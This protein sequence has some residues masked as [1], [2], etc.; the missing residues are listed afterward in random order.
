MFSILYVDDEPD[1][2]DL[3]KIFLEQSPDFHVAINT[4]AIGALALPE[5]GSFD[6]IISDFQMPEMDGIAFLKSIRATRGNVP[7]IL[8]TGRGREEIVI[9]AINNGVDFYLQKGG[10]VKAQFAELSHKIRQAV[11]RRRAEQSLVESEKRLTDII[12]FLPDP[13]FAI[14]R[15]GEII[16]WNHAIEEMTGQ[17]ASSMLGKGDHE[18]AIPFYGERR[19]ILI[20]LVFDTDEKISQYY[21]N[22]LHEGVSITAETNLPHPKGTQITVLAKASPL[23]NREGEIVGAI[24]SIRDITSRKKADD[25][26]RAAYEQISASEEE[27]REQVEALGANEKRIRESES[28]L[29][30]MIGFYQKAREPERELLSYA[31][32]GAGVITSSPLGYLAFLNED[33]SE[34][35]M[36]AWSR[37]AMKECSIR[38]KPIIYKTSRTGLWGEAVRQRLPVI[39]NDYAAPNPA[40]KGYPD[41]HPIITRHMNIPVMDDGHVVLVAGVANK[42]G[43]YTDDDVQELSLL[44]QSLWLVL[45]R[46][47]TEQALLESENKYRDLFENSVT[48]IFRTTFE[49]TFSAINTAFARI[50]GYDTPREMMDAITDI[51]TQL[52]VNPK[53]RVRFM[54]ILKSVGMVKD[55]HVQFYHRNG[56]TRWVKMNAIAVRD[57][58]GAVRYYEGTIEDISEQKRAEQ[59]LL[60]EKKFSDAVVDSVPGLLYLYDEDGL[61]IR[62]N[63]AH[64]TITGYSAEELGRMHLLDWYTGDDESIAAVNEGIRRTWETGSASAEANLQIKNGKK[65]PFFLTAQ[66]LEIEGKT[67]FTGVGIDITVQRK[68]KDD[69]QAAYE[70]LT[71]N[72]EELREQVEELAVRQ[73]AL[74]KSEEKFRD[75]VE[76]SPDL[77]WEMDP[78]GV[79]TYMS[80]QCTDMIGYTPEETIGRSVFSLVP[81]DALPSFRTIFSESI[82]TRKPPRGI[83]VPIQCRNGHIITVEIRAVALIDPP[84]ALRGFRGIARDITEKRKAAENLRAAYEQ[85]TASNEELQGQYEELAKSETRI[86]A[87]EEQ[88][89]NIIDFSPLGMHFYEFSKD[90]VLVFTGANPAADAILGIDHSKLLGK[91]IEDAFPGLVGTE[92]PDQYRQVARTGEPWHTDQV[93]YE[94]G[95]IRGAFSATAFQIRSGAIAAVFFD[96]TER[97]KA[98]IALRLSEERLQLALQGAELGTWNWNVTTGEVI[99]SERWA[100]MIGYRLDEIVP[101]VK[102]WEQ[103]VHP[104]DLPRVQEIL[105]AHLDGKTEVYECEHRMHHKNGSWVWVLDKGMVTERDDEGRPL[106]A[107][108][109]HLDITQRK[110]A[111]DELREKTEALDQFFTTSLDLLCIADTDGYFRRLNPEWEKTLGYTLDELEGHRFIDFV[112]PDDLQATLTT[113]SQLRGQH[114]VLNFTNRYRHS[115]GS[116]R[117]IEWR[118]RSIGSLI[119]ATARDITQRKEIE[120][121][122]RA[123]E[124]RYRTVIDNIQDG[125]VR[126]DTAGTLVMASLSAA[127]MVGFDSAD[128]LLGSSMNRFYYRPEARQILL[129]QIAKNGHVSE[130]EIEFVRKDGTVFWGSVNAHLLYDETGKVT[131][132]EAVLREIT[133]RRRMEHAI[134]EANRKLNLLNSITRHDVANQLTALQGFVQIASMLKTDPVITDYLIKIGNVANTITRQ[135]EFTRTYQELGITDPAWF[136]IEGIVTN[137]Q[138]PVPVKFSGTCRGVEIFA[139]PMLERVFFNLFDNAVRHGVR[140]TGITVRCERDPDG[141]VIIVEDDGIGVPVTE[142]DKIFGRGYGSHTGLGLFLAKE[143]LSITRITIRETGIPGHGARFEMLVP[144]GSYRLVK[145]S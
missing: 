45:K 81:D 75:I 52:Y 109:T 74:K 63:K 145:S 118:S 104:D 4:S 35:S 106:L 82:R 115:N 72:E 24:E 23:Y 137:A 3:A 130:Y 117:W 13:T 43:D 59:E 8:F 135:I 33:E 49:G 76:T 10:D 108:G 125:F 1:L 31:V 36:Y 90:G 93:T 69:L 42:P 51:G 53:D 103:L 105:T 73:A 11:A 25:E 58:Q 144:K 14:N 16:A 97:K 143:I 19:P 60:K 70:N 9:E 57:L 87:S 54:D 84:D 92:I 56:S 129:D 55:F 127:R 47:R 86:R 83:D 41:G 136:G 123:S 44:M 15:E 71:A 21:N 80:P 22:L 26:L 85:L 131:G 40:K 46:R 111:E 79:F 120:E 99:F 27:L 67:Y 29:R 101:S 12:D 28:R 140:V 110:L 89:R 65:I 91:S 98:E 107:A 133:E 142:K 95:E 114:E 126:V 138:S 20:D 119:I 116:Y 2:L 18:Y 100:E 17:S 139:D 5:I 39:T 32:E 88:F 77:I 50:S 64:E 113:M 62:W 30:Y 121:A 66:R 7:F 96:I 134:R 78:E 122:L 48:G 102:S 112:H 68:A 6:A 34:L 124:E 141:F 94:K 37:S 128:D 61:L 132:T 38:E